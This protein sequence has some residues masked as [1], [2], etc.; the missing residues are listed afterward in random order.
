M[1]D[2]DVID[3]FV[4]QLRENGHPELRVDR[5]PDEDNRQSADIDAV[6]G[7]FAIEHTSID[8]LPNQ[9]R[10]SDW[11]M[12]AAGNL[13]QEIEAPP[14]RLNITLEYDAVGTGQNWAAIREALKDWIRSSAPSLPEGRSL[15]EDAPG[16]PFRL[17][18]IKSSERRP[19]VFFARYEPDNDTLPE[20]VKAAFNRKTEKLAKY[21]G[22][23][24]TTILLVENDDIALMNE[25]KMLEA[26]RTAFPSGPPHG[27]DQ[28]WYADTSIASA[29]EFRELTRELGKRAV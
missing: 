22:P 29:L 14:F 18:V 13:E 25:W 5:R 27:V 3:A 21:Q 20:R 8:T 1:N 10:D 15:I 12:R 24:V 11:F 7:Q 17:H 6:A 26:I 19:G 9:R 4:A 23:G 28:V 2:H 16:I